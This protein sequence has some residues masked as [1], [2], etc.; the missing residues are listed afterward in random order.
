MQV[1][2]KVTGAVLRAAV[3]L[4]MIALVAV[5]MTNVIF[6]YVL[7]APLPWAEEF[8][9]YCMVYMAYLA[10]PLA[11]REGRHVRIT[12]IT[13]RLRGVWADVF[14]LVAYLVVACL[15]IPVMYH[16]WNLVQLVSFQMTPAMRISMSIPYF[17]VALGM[18]FLALES[19]V[20]FI[21]GV[22]RLV[23][24]EARRAGEPLTRP[25]SRGVDV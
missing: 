24:G 20:L 23:R 17:G 25:E 4:L 6:R 15:A 14:Q 18:A 11:L 1:V 8:A 13:D 2:S 10:A 7:K 21:D 22:I 19:I 16:G 5:V 12:V 9:R 3:G